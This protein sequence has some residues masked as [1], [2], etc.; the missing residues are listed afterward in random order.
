MPKQNETPF[1]AHIFVCTNDRKGVRKSCADN[2]SQLIKARLKEFV[3]GNGWKGKVRVSSAGCLG[4]CEKGPNVIIYPQRIWFSAVCAA[5]LD[6]IKS[7]V[8]NI[9]EGAGNEVLS[10]KNSDCVDDSG[11]GRR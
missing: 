3:N 10:D 9:L 8:E 5:E 2:D 4:L 11:S 1:I 7:V 6:E